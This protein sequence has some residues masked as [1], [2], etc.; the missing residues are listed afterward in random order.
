MATQDWLEAKALLEEKRGLL[1]AWGRFVLFQLLEKNGTAHSQEVIHVLKD[2][3]ILDGYKGK[4]FWIG[5]VFS[6]P[7]LEKTGKTIKHS[8]GGSHERTNPVWR[9]EK[10]A[11]GPFPT[12]PKVKPLFETLP[13]EIWSEERYIMSVAKNALADVYEATDLEELNRDKIYNA[14]KHVRDYLERTEP[15]VEEDE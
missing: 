7:R 8:E 15:K 2:M 6:D 9:I 4:N 14:L 11:K 13:D 3:E 10:G 1:I 12:A 5:A